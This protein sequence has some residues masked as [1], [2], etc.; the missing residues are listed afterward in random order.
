MAG[1]GRSADTFNG[2]APAGDYGWLH[3][4]NGA[5]LLGLW[6]F[7][8]AAYE[9]LPDLVPGHIGPAGVTRWDAKQNS[10]WFILPLMGTVQVIVMYGL[11]A[12][13]GGSP[14]GLNMPEKQRLLALSP[15]GQ[16]YALQPF[17][18][19]MFGMATWLL[20]LMSYIQ[21]TSYAIAMRGPATSA[22]VGSMLAVIGLAVGVVIVMS[23]WLKRAIS[24]RV[25]EWELREPPA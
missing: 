16:R 10:M 1:S 22:P 15:E 9:R 25:A 19:F 7:S 13:A 23:L 11:S 12:I 14:T 21:L 4:V 6:A 18:G 2:T 3:W 8:I 5:L 17:R 20:G 24:R